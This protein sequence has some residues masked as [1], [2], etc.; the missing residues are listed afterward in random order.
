LRRRA[1]KY[2][3]S[4]GDEITAA[5]V[6]AHRPSRYWFAVPGIL[7]L[8]LILLLQRRRQQ[9]RPAIAT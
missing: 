9:L 7:L 5:L 6:P 1:A 3:L 2:G 4:P 8:V